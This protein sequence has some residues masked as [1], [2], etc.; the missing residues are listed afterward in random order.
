MRVLVFGR[1]D[2][3]QI[4]GG[5]QFY[6]ASLVYSLRQQP[7]MIVDC[8][9]SSLGNK[10]TIIDR[11]TGKNISVG[12][13]ATL[14]SVPISPGM[15]YWAWKLIKKKKRYDVIHLNFPDPMALLVMLF[16]PTKIPIVVTWHSD[17]VRQKWAL[18]FYL[19]LLK[20]FMKRV[21]RIIVA[22]PYHLRSCPQLK[23]LQ[24]EHKI[25][26]IPFGID[27]ARW[28]PNEKMLRQAQGI[29][30]RFPNKFILFA[31]GR[32]VYY[33]GFEYL[34]EAL[35][36]LPNC[37][38]ILGGQ[39]P[40]TEKLRQ[41]SWVLRV[42]DRITFVDFISEEELPTF[43]HACDVFCFPSVAT[44]EAF[45]YA[46]LEAM[47]CGKPV[48]AGKLNNGVNF[49]SLDGETGIAVPTKNAEKLSEAIE[50]LRLDEALLK[51]YSEAAK[52]RA[53]KEFT[54]EKM[55]VRTH[56]LFRDLIAKSS[57][58]PS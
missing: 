42:V 23:A 53:H 8:L 47:M 27:P 56:R 19:P 49:V 37:H 2:F 43:Y 16:I 30:S 18:A 24:M 21:S 15:L 5:V 50:K 44:T 52:V 7:G 6:A 20:L 57:H 26:V 22:T 29:R 12:T 48:I 55:A 45:G 58:K 32:H 36:T 13:L 10:T 11:P 4:K 31:F 39:G 28:Q 3:D 40:L 51:R 34:V 14:A 35:R 54:M 1:Y 9:V 25:V 33:K 41:M 46:Q 38:L 17:V